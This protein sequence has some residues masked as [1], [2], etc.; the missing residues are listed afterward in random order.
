MKN[1][2]PFY[3]IW[4]FWLIVVVL[5]VVIFG[6][7]GGNSDSS[8][9][10]S[11]NKASGHS[12]T[13][14]EKGNKKSSS[15]SN[16]KVLNIDYTDRTV[17]DQKNYNLSFTDTS[18]QPE[19]IKVT[20]V[21]VFKMKPFVYDDSSKAKAQGFII[22]HMAITAN[23]DITSYPDQGTVITSDGQQIDAALN[24]VKGYKENFGGD[25]AKGVTKEGD[26]MAPVEKLNNVSDIK[27]LRLKFDG[28]YDTDNYEDENAQHD[29]DIT[30]NLNQ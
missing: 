21:Q 19:T 20:K 12:T 28:S 2:K 9:K 18:W 23:R 17:L 6:M 7:F 4:W 15:K 14:V 11:S 25:I 30:L 10:S 13:E 24:T 26:I 27:S 8:D 22:I 3:K 16:N 1:N 5:V 29:Y